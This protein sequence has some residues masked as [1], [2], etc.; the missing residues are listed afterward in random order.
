MKVNIHGHSHQ[1]EVEAEGEL[2]DVVEVARKLWEATFQPE[3]GPAGPAYGFSMERDCGL[4]I[5]DNKRWGGEIEPVRA[6]E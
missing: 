6:V 3:R 2:H 4:Q 5:G 1:V